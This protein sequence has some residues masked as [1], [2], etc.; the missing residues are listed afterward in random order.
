VSYG[1]GETEGQPLC[2]GR[3]HRIQMLGHLAV[4]LAGLMAVLVITRPLQ[5]M[6]TEEIATVVAEAYE[7]MEEE[8]E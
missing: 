2:R 6:E 7:V 4:V 5:R 8:E 3:H 1:P